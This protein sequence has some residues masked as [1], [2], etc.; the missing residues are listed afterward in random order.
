MSLPLAAIPVVSCPLC[1]HQL[2]KALPFHYDFEGV[3]FLG[4]ECRRCGL[5]GLLRQPALH[6]FHRLYADE[7]FTS[8][9]ARCGHLEDYFADRPALV[10]EGEGLSSRFERALGRSGRL[11]DVGCASGAVLEAAAG[12]G[13]EVQGVEFSEAASAEAW[14]HGIP[15]H[16]GSLESARFPNGTF[17]VVFLGDTLEHVPDPAAM[18]AEVSRVL[19]PGGILY[20]RCPLT[21][22]SFARRLALRFMQVFG[23]QLTLEGPPYHLWEFVPGTLKLLVEGAGLRIEYFRQAKVPP[24]PAKRP[25]IQGWLLYAVDLVNLVWTLLTRS[26]GDRCELVARKP[27]AAGI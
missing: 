21:T 2:F 4:G 10:R 17:D 20:L 22:N 16:V 11:L 12:R 1:K 13:W 6:E 8:G 15:V 25:G 23:K 14:A 24:N 26:A 5:R 19:A 3:R 9:D 27:M 7:Y 18:L